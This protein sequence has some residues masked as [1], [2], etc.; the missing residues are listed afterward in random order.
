MS[1]ISSS[2]AH[3]WQTPNKHHD[4]VFSALQLMEATTFLSHELVEFDILQ[5]THSTVAHE[6]AD[7]VQVASAQEELTALDAPNASSSFMTE[8]SPLIQTPA[9][10][11]SAWLVAMDEGGTQG[12]RHEALFTDA[13]STE[14]FVSTVNETSSIDT[15]AV[16]LLP[17]WV[18]PLPILHIP[19]G[20]QPTD[21]GWSAHSGWGEINVAN[22]LKAVLGQ[23][24]AEPTSTLNAP[25]HIKALGFDVAWANGFTGQGVIVADIDTGID[26]NNHALIQSMRLS[27]NSWNFVNHSSNVQDDNGHGTMTA[28]EIGS[29]YDMGHGAIGAAYGAEVMVLKALD[30]MGQGSAQTIGEAIHYAVDHGASVINLSLGTHAAETT[31]QTAMQYAYA[32]DVIVVAAAGN[33]GNASV[34]FP[35]AYAKQ[36]SNVIA[37]GASQ[38]LNQHETLASYSNQASQSTAYNFVDAIGSDLDGFTLDGVLATWSGTSMASPLVAAQAAILKSANP[39]LT[40]SQIVED[41]FRTTDS[42]DDFLSNI[43]ATS[44]SAPQPILPMASSSAI[45]LNDHLNNFI[46]TD[47]L[48]TGFDYVPTEQYH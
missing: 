28:M 3:G 19:Q 46:S 37:V 20:L 2:N 10:H 8:L 43:P 7:M 32:H 42:L 5:S 11:H 12:L 38:N 18:P 6:P 48:S 21:A 40:A 35:A 29:Q 25:D 41:I 33:E 1:N 36:F 34:D 22:S 23:A 26:L 4:S 39:T 15:P 47:H 31:I 30:A 14:A 24:L 44:T 17:N 27:T 9:Q 16:H 13:S 45:V